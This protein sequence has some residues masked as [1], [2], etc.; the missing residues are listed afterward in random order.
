MYMHNDFNP[1]APG[2]II[3]HAGGSHDLVGWKTN[4][5]FNPIPVVAADGGVD[6]L[7]TI[8]GNDAWTIRPRNA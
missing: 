5:D 3:E 2:W 6:E 1:V 4:G 8:I 7:R